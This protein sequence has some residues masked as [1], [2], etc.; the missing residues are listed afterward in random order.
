MVSDYRSRCSGLDPQCYQIF[1]AEVV[2]GLL[3]PVRIIEELLGKNGGG[4]GLRNLD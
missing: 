4:S 3:S 2:Q 1:C